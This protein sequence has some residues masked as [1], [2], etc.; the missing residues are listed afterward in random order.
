[1]SERGH[2]HQ[3]AC[4]EQLSLAY[5]QAVAAAAG[6]A[7]ERRGVDHYGVDGSFHHATASNDDFDFDPKQVEA[8]LKCTTQNHLGEVTLAYPGLKK[9]HY[10]RLRTP[11]VNTPRILIVMLV[12][13]DVE[14]WLLQSETDLVVTGCAYWVSLRDQD[15][16]STATT[17]VHLPRANVFGVESLLDM[18]QRVGEG[19]LP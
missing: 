6:C 4:Q 13:P 18:M 16:I 3:T 17:T 11:K 2:L 12:P 8:Q 1:V 19:G 10:N 5:G 7:F 14:D 15:P 9:Q